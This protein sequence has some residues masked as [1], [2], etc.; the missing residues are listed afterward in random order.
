MNSNNQILQFDDKCVIIKIRDSRPDVFNRVRRC[1]KMDIIRARQ[2]DYVLAVII[3]RIV[4]VYKP[5]EWY[6]TFQDNECNKCIK[7]ENKPCNGKRI[8]FNGNE[9]E[10]A[11]QKKY[12]HKYL[13]DSFMKPGPGAIRYTY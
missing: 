3:G 1:W 6:V 8:G 7:C 2:A 10:V 9:A 11:I 4:G 13:P 12:L 5:E